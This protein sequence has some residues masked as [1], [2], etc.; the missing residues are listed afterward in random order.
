[1]HPVWWCTF[2]QKF[3]ICQRERYNWVTAKTKQQLNYLQVSKWL[4]WIS[5]GVLWTTF[6]N[7]YKLFKKWGFPNTG[8]QPK[9]KQ[10]LYISSS[11]VSHQGNNVDLAQES[12]SAPCTCAPGKEG[13]FLCYRWRH[14]IQRLKD[15][16]RQAQV[17]HNFPFPARI[18]NIIGLACQQW[19]ADSQ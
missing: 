11:E 6:L 18:L 1:M 17:W 16:V 3:T 4:R 7:V 5:W 15:R 8:R 2:N 14:M 13:A 10:E 12:L 19:Q 9:G